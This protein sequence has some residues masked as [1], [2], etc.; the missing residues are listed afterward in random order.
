MK[1]SAGGA[2]AYQRH[3]GLLHLGLGQIDFLLAHRFDFEQRPVTIPSQAG[4]G[5]ICLGRVERR[6]I[7][8]RVDAKQGGAFLSTQNRNGRFPA[9]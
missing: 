6:L 7:V 3:F 5:Q 1:T 4:D 2:G 8:A 9:K